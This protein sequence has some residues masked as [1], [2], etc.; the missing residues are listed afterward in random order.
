V[1]ARLTALT[2]RQARE[3]SQ[4]IDASLR[5]A[6]RQQDAAARAEWRA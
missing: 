3:G 5:A 6:A 4:A 1:E 2:R